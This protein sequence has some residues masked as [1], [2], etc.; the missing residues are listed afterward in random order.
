MGQHSICILG[1][2]GFVGR[3]LSARL[4][5]E[6][7]RVRVLSR[8]RQRGKDL[9]VLPTAEVVEADVHDPEALKAQ[10][11][12]CDT[13]V[14]LVGILNARDATGKDF[15]RAHAELPRKVVEACRA[16]GVGRLLHM[17]ALGGDAAY[18]ASHY[19]RSKGEGEN[20]VHNAHDLAVTS[21]RPSVIFGP[22]DSFLNRFA[23]LLKMSPLVFPLACAGARFAPVY[24]KDVAEAYTRALD[25]RNTFGQRYDLCGPNAYTL[26]ELVTYVA[27]LRHLRRWIIPLGDGPSKLMASVLEW[28]PGKPLT[29]D[30]VLSMQRDNVCDG[31]FPEVFGFE[32]TPLESVAPFYLGDAQDE[33]DAHRKRAR[34]EV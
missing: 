34:R 2:N 3:H 24:V 17:S 23:G 6:G 16:A 4:V 11:A 27:R 7:H 26:Q 9:L 18:G 12:D 28:A 1:G 5:E 33:F 10:F 8:H 30:N 32:P 15:Y 29:R 19:Q 22:G 13:V 31:P 21:F 25:N 14:N 20:L